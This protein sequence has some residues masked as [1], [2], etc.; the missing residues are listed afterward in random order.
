M[1]EMKGLELM[2]SFVSDS[3]LSAKGKKATVI[4]REVQAKNINFA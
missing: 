4:L 3:N 2:Q 1:K